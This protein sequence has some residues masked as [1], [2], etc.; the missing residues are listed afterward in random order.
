[1]AFFPVYIMLAASSLLLGSYAD[2]DSIGKLRYY[3]AKS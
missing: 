3:L 2:S 1:M